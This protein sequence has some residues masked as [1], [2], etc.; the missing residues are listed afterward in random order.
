MRVGANGC[1]TMRMTPGG[2]LLTVI[3]LTFGRARIG[4]V[5]GLNFSTF[6]DTW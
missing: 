5:R 6:D 1:F 4:Y 2:D 3:P